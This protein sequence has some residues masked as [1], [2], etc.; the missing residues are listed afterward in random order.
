MA[1]LGR[2]RAETCSAVGQLRSLPGLPGVTFGRYQGGPH[3]GV[4]GVYCSGVGGAIRSHRTRRERIQSAWN[5]FW[6]PM[7]RLLNN[8]PPH[9]DQMGPMEATIRTRA[10]PWSAAVE[11]GRR[12]RQ[13][14]DIPDLQ[15]WVESNGQRQ[16]WVE[17]NGTP[18]SCA[19]HGTGC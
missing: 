19:G 6:A 8:K 9:Q 4:L 5:T 17:S 2:M 11:V 18:N 14:A 12:G 15:T 13:E 7:K 10:C 16:T 1:D 3:S